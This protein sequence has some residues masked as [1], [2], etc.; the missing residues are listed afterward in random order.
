MRLRC[1]DHDISVD[2][3]DN[4]RSTTLNLGRGAHKGSGPCQ[5]LMATDPAP[6]EAKNRTGTIVCHIVKEA[7]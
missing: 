5:L 2:M 7:D 6:G 1:T 3:A 4:S